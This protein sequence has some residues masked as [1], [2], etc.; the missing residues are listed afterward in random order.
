[1]RKILLALGTLMAVDDL[2]AQDKDSAAIKAFN[3]TTVLKEV[4]VQGKKPAFQILP[5]K[6]IVNVDASVSNTGT[7]VLEVLEKSPGVTFDRNG[8]ISLKGRQ[9]V[10]IMIDGKPTQISGADLNNLLSGMTASQVE[11]IEIIDNPSAKYDAAGNAG[12]IN[13]RTK[14]NRQKGFN[15]NLSLA[16]AQGKYT[17]SINTITLNKYSGKINL[18]AT[19]GVNALKNFSDVYAHRKYYL[20]DEKTVTA[21]LE[22]PSFFKGR[23]PAETIKTGIDYFINKKTTLG[24]VLSGTLFAR[25]GTGNNT[26]RWMNADDMVDSIILTTTKTEEKL[27]SGS[28]NLNMRHVFN[29]NQE[30][31]ADL[32][33]LGYNINNDQYFTN[34]LIEPQGYTEYIQG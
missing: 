4:T 29:A 20:E 24:T 14:K 11:T 5:D 27:R 3:D 1:M 32:D 10:M 30:L 28:A 15:G 31:T 34:S 21:M 6:T 12:I 23:M 7:T 25:H 19:F 22:Q 9:G 8:N 33:F 18:F 17:R 16:L 26:A 2:Q 13:I